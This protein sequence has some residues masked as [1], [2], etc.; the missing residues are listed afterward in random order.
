MLVIFLIRVYN[1]LSYSGLSLIF[2]KGLKMKR[3][4]KALLLSK[5]YEFAHAVNGNILELRHP[6][7]ISIQQS[8]KF[9]E[10]L[11]G[12]YIYENV[13]DPILHDITI[14]AWHNNTDELL[15]DTV[16]HELCHA[17]QIET[18][19]YCNYLPHDDFFFTTLNAILVNSG[20]D[21]ADEDYITLH[22]G[23]D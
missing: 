10:N 13:N 23:S 5:A 6:I 12:L 4:Q 8:K 18:G 21:E 1:T 22:K 3:H 17:K 15:F 14:S 2:R 16:I 9:A 11:N 19:N 7:V 20:L